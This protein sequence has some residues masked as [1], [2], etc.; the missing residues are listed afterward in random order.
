MEGDF[1]IPVT[2]PPPPLPVD[3]PQ[4]YPPC[5]CS[6]QSKIYSMSIQILVFL[7]NAHMG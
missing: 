7:S 5:L 6:R 3:P 1:A 2:Q 4:H